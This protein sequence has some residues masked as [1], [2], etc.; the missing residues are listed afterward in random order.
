MN[1]QINLYHPIF[2]KEQKKFSAQTMLQASAVVAVAVVLLIAANVWQIRSLQTANA[3]AANDL[4]ATTKQIETLAKLP[5]R[6][7]DPQVL[8]EQRQLE[9][10]WNT[11][12]LVRGN[13]SVAGAVS[14]GYS[15]YFRGLA[16]QHVPGLWLTAITVADSGQELVLQGRTPTPDAVPTYVQRLARE[17]VFAG[18]QFDLFEITRPVE[19]T[20]KG[21]IRAPYLEFVIRSKYREAKPG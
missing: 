11:A 12:Q 1:Q 9:Q 21:E 3:R 13:A 8:A 14:N 19:V 4:S 20:A 6:A 18:K 7:A 10:A 17:P 2:R 15:E 5:N 16:R